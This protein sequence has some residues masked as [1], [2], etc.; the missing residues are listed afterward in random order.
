MRNQKGFTLIELI[1]VIVVLGI[2][3]VTAAPQFIDF[4]SDAR[5][6]AV[7]GVK[8]ALQGASQ[9]IYSKAAIDGKL[10]ADDEVLGIGTAYGYPEA[11]DTESTPSGEPE[12]AEAADLSITELTDGNE[13]TD[14]VYIVDGTTVYIGPAGYIVAGGSAAVS[15][16]TAANGTGGEGCYVS[17]K[18]ATSTNGVVT[19]PAITSDTDGC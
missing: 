15:D 18:T 13:T 7:K 1:I 14:F 9:T 3:A 11:G 5:A 17:Y 12:I 8:G 16:F 19:P 2:L 10:G 6:S 4:S